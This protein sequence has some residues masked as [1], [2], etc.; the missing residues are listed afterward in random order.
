MSKKTRTSTTRP[1]VLPILKKRGKTRKRET[2]VDVEQSTNPTETPATEPALETPKVATNVETET[3]PTVPTEAA[4]PPVT[5]TPGKAKGNK[6]VKKE[7]KPK[8]M[9][10]LNAAAK[11]LADA[12]TPMNCQEMIEAMA[13]A[14]LWS[15]PNGQTPAATLY[16]AILR[17]V[18]TKGKDAR[19]TKTERGK[20]AAKA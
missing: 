15:S 5:E 9:S 16:S 8:K 17:E 3:T 6:K 14:K 18:N 13:K 10:A 2:Q 12:G 19:F 7:D 4:Q 1:S 20:F 11:V